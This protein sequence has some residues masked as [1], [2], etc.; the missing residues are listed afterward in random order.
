MFIFS[1]IIALVTSP[2]WPL[3]PNPLPGDPYIIVNKE[4]NQLAYFQ[5][6]ELKEVHTVSTGKSVELT[7]EGEFNIIVKAINPYYRKKNIAGGDPNN[8]L[9]SRWMGFDAQDTEGRTYG[10]HGTNRPETIGG[11]VTLGCI[12]LENKV[13]EELFNKVPIGTKIWIIRSGKSFE[14]LGREK[15]VLQ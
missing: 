1:L 2:L 11:Y 5:G 3:G 4:T 14:E 7:P 15:G 12:R 13:V 9:G 10:V 6:E 8:P